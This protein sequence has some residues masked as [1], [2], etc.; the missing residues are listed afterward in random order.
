MNEE[1]KH[2]RRGCATVVVLGE[3]GSDTPEYH[4]LKMVMALFDTSGFVYLDGVCSVDRSR[5]Y[6]L[7]KWTNAVP[8][9]LPLL[10]WLNEV[11]IA[12]LLEH[13]H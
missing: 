10:M 9:T 8:S 5:N 4:T 1:P 6:V 12:S 13:K 3:K 2:V 11:S 7:A